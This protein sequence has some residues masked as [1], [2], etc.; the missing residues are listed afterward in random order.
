MSFFCCFCIF[1]H[2]CHRQLPCPACPRGHTPAL[3]YTK[4]AI[5]FRE[6]RLLRTVDPIWMDTR[7]SASA[8]MSDVS[9]EMRHDLDAAEQSHS[10]ADTDADPDADAAADAYLAAI[11]GIG[12]D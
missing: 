6:L 5:V 1:T 4:V 12:R 11:E 8:M 7:P 10:R 9:E 2:T 3:S